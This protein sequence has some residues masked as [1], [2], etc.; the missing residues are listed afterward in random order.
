MRNWFA[1]VAL[2]AVSGCGF[3]PNETTK[4]AFTKGMTVASESS[5]SA[6]NDAGFTTRYRSNKPVREVVADARS[7]LTPATGWTEATETGQMSTSTPPWTAYVF[8][9]NA[10]NGSFQIRISEDPAGQAATLVSV[11][12]RVSEDR[13][14]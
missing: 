13:M 8:K 6:G 7:E 5:D 11:R 4:F 14:L 3:A 1:L 2:A 9:K 12:Q 10:G